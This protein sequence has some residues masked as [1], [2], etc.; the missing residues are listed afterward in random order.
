MTLRALLVAALL[1]I[2][3]ARLFAQQQLPYDMGV[4]VGSPGAPVV[5]AVWLDYHCPTCAWLH[6]NFLP[7][8]DARYV[9]TGKVR[10]VIFDLPLPIHPGSPNTAAAVRCAGEQGRGEAMRDLVFRSQARLSASAG[11][12]DILD[13]FGR[14]V[15]LDS[16]A[17][18][19]CLDAPE[20]AAVLDANRSLAAQLGLSATP[21]FAVDGVVVVGTGRQLV[22]AVERALARHR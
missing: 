20:T 19:R 16:G 12:R 2:S 22:E 1:C 4:S 10:R 18:S 9:A 21:T 5:V 14:Q 7:A 3:P 6:Q 11:S 13:Q 17:F 15:G 8:F